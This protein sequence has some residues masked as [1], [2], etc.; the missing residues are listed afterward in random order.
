MQLHRRRPHWRPL[1]VLVPPDAP[2]PLPLAGS[3]GRGPLPP[4]PGPSWAGLSAKGGAPAPSPARPAARS[5]GVLRPWPPSPSVFLSGTRFRMAAGVGTRRGGPPPLPAPAEAP[6]AHLSA[7]S[8]LV[9]SSGD[10]GR[11][12]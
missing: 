12:G 5:P 1:Q 6:G 3:P 11:G 8:S 7:P 9:S 10:G 4:N 2:S